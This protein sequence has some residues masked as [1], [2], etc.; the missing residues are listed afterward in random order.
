MVTTLAL[1][2]LAASNG[3]ALDAAERHLADRK[4][5]DV[6]FALDG[7]TWSKEE[8]PRAAG[9]LAKLP[10]TI[11]I[12]GH[13]DSIPMRGARFSSNWHL[14]AARA[15]SVVRL[16]LGAGVDARRMQVVGYGDVRPR[17]SNETA[18]G[19]GQNRRIEIKIL[20]KASEAS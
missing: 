5:D 12:E 8:A 2:L 9:I 3:E 14:S 19:R 11:R 18:E 15:Q 7:K 20:R 17:A 1:L 6:F 4:V 16:L 13:T 10:N